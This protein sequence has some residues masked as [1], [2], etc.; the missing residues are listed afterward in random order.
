MRY[1][2][3]KNLEK[4]QPQSSKRLPWIKLMTE[5]LEP[6]RQPWYAELP[7]ATKALL[8]HVWL[9]AAALGGRIPEDWLTRERLNL[10]SKISL[11]SILELGLVW[12][13]NE[14]GSQSELS[15]ARL[16]RSGTL[17][18]GSLDS[19][20]ENR[21]PDFSQDLA[22]SAI[23]SDYPRRIGRKEAFRHFRATVKTP[24]DFAAIRA[25]L[26]NFRAEMADRPMKFIQQGERWFNNW[27]DWVD[28]VPATPIR[29]V[30]PSLM[31]GAAVV[32][33]PVEAYE[34]APE[35]NP[36][37]EVVDALGSPEWLRAAKLIAIDGDTLTVGVPSQRHAD[38]IRERY[39]AEIRERLGDQHA[40]LQVVD[41]V[42]SRS[43][44]RQRAVSA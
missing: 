32:D 14:N 2:R 5:L 13:E 11:D 12:F 40:Y 43:I 41:W 1:L 8:H 35:P 4:Y 15:H 31:V 17:P 19:P 18:S 6:T 37:S 33:A 30:D 21:E 20:T 28:V 3:V 10:K 27:R 34:P 29:N 24:D 16:T 38:E 22:F 44:E 39:G 36:W 9:M 26:V 23:W 7:D 42:E 25:A